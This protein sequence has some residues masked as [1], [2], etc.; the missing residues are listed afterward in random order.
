[1]KVKDLIKHL[2]EVD[3]NL[4][5]VLQRDSEGNGYQLAEDGIDVGE[6]DKDEQHFLGGDEVEDLISCGERSPRKKFK[7]NAIVLWPV[8]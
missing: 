1:M 7:P 4:K 3:P 5:V 6:W 8:W 2:S